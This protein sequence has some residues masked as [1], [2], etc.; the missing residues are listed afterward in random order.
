M[1]IRT[2]R[3]EVGKAPSAKKQFI[4]TAKAYRHR[5]HH[6]FYQENAKMINPNPFAFC[7]GCWLKPCLGQMLDR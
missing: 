4:A 6:R 5:D 2:K 3:D 1:T 7:P